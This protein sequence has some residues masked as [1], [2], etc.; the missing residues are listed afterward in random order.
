MTASCRAPDTDV[1][2]LSNYQQ[3][4]KQQQHHQ[5]GP[6]GGG[7]GAL[8]QMQMRAAQV[9]QGNS[10]SALKINNNNNHSNVLIRNQARLGVKCRQPSVLLNVYHREF[11]TELV[12]LVA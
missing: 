7:V 6:W 12:V 9:A 5:L 2:W 4:V 3:F 11:V 8:G 1:H 10:H